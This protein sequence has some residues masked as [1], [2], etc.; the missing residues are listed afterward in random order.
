[1]CKRHA[2]MYEDL[3]TSLKFIMTAI[4][5]CSKGYL[6][7]DIFS[8]NKLKMITDSVFTMIEKANPS[9]VLS[10]NHNIKYYDM[11]VVTFG[12]DDNDSL[13]ITFPVFGK[14]LYRESRVLYETLTV[15][16]PIND[17]NEVANSYSI[18]AVFKTIWPKNYI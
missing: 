11:K 10:F 14:A 7:P 15:L 12:V 9:Y 16:V 3:M 8:P 13:V 4:T 6:S 17:L 18:V 1:M 5:K 2:S